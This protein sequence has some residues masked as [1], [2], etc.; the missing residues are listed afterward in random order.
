MYAFLHQ[1]HLTCLQHWE[2]HCLAA[3]SR[4]HRDFCHLQS[5]EHASPL[6]VPTE[7]N[8]SDAP[9]WLCKE[10][11]RGENTALLPL[12]ALCL[13]TSPLQAVLPF[14]PRQSSSVLKSSWLSKGNV[15]G[16]SM[17]TTRVVCFC[18]CFLKSFTF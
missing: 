16:F 18:F 1:K 10:A 6:A 12:A 15:L 11:P 7:Q 9:R 3:Q 4:T 13:Q 8:N 17:Y 5:A 14:L 2:R